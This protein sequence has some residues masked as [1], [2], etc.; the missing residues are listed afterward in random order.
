M[1]REGERRGQVNCREANRA[2]RGRLCRERGRKREG[3]K[4]REREERVIRAI[5]CAENGVA[6]GSCGPRSAGEH[7]E[8]VGVVL[9]MEIQIAHDGHE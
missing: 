4:E 7:G 1:K 5:R 3:E 6:G 2:G 8:R 9:R